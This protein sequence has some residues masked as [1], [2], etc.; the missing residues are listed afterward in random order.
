MKVYQ[1]KNILKYSIN[2]YFSK[3]LGWFIMWLVL[4]IISW[5]VFIYHDKKVPTKIDFQVISSKY[6]DKDSSF[7]VAKYK[8][9]LI[10]T[11][12]NADIIFNDT[13]YQTIRPGQYYHIK[14]FSHNSLNKAY[15]INYDTNTL[16]SVTFCMF[17]VILS[18]VLLFM[19]MA[20]P[21]SAWK[22]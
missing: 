4:D 8:N 5:T 20:I 18:M 14:Y 16:A 10:D 3:T 15:G 12:W 21:T 7:V 11:L 13:V 1:F 9:N 6:V 17:G 22:W 19:L 2:W